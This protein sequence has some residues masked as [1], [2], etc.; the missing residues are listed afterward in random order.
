[1]STHVTRAPKGLAA[2]AYA[3][4]ILVSIVC[5]YPYWWM[6]VSAFRN[7]QAIMT[8]PLRPWP[9]TLSLDVLTEIASVGG[10]PLWR[11]AL[12]SVLITT[13]STVVGIVVTALGAYAIVRRPDFWLFR[14]LRLG[15]MVTI[16]YPYMLLVIPVY[17]VMFKIGLLGSY[18]G[19]VLFL[20][21]GPI[22]FFLFE[23][24][25]RAIPNSVIE[26]AVIDG[27]NEWQILWSVVMP[28]ALPVVATASIIT[29]LLNWAQWLPVLVVSKSP[30]TYTLPVALMSLNGELGVNFQGIMA[31]AVLTTIPVTLFFLLAQRRVISGMTA[32]AVKG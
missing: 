21:L 26:A 23:Q 10:T 7:T 1:M 11:Y 30:D 25:F 16:M 32:G 2:L 18:A 15:F 4:A 8:S 17:I 27:A 19:I 6:L 14:V 28:L 5:L 29:F 3:A 9:E 20:A 22:Q 31:L 13:A 24:F 12:N